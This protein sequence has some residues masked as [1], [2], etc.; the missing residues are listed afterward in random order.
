[1]AC[2]EIFAIHLGLYL[3]STIV[4]GQVAGTSE[5][6]DSGFTRRWTGKRRVRIW[7]R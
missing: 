6:A 1:M 3:T 7:A 2:R 4:C 5:P